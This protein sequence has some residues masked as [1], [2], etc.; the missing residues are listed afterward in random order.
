MGERRALLPAP[1]Y[2]M[3]QQSLVF[4]LSPLPE[5]EGAK[6][7]GAEN[8]TLKSDDLE[9]HSVLAATTRP[10]LGSVVA[11]EGGGIGVRREVL[12]IG[13]ML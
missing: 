7:V 4:P 13:A 6:T 2:S 3:E 8:L 10:Y 12:E 5:G 9:A 11:Q 1:L